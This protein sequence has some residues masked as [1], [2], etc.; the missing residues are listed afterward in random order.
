MSCIEKV[1]I[2]CYITYKKWRLSTVAKSRKE[3]KSNG[4]STD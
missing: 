4:K 1:V 3:I 2:L